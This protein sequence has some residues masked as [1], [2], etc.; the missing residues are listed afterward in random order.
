MSKL[1]YE[2]EA[3]SDSGGSNSTWIIDS[4]S[5]AQT[6][7]ENYYTNMYFYS[8]NHTNCP[9]Y[10]CDIV[11]DLNISSQGVVISHQPNNRSSEL[12]LLKYQVPQGA[13]FG[14]TGF[15]V[16]FKTTQ[17]FYWEAFWIRCYS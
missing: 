16:H 12:S 9:I 1:I 8:T 14:I 2:Y 13:G 6:Y 10:N 5:L 3:G 11:T 7:D 17:F 4:S 15:Q